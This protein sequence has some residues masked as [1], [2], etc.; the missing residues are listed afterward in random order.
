MKKTF[1]SYNLS[2]LLLLP[3]SIE[4]WVRC[5]C[6][7]I[8]GCSRVR[9]IYVFWRGMAMALNNTALYVG[10]TLGSLIGGWVIAKCA[11][12]TLPLICAVIAL[13]GALTVFIR[14]RGIP[15]RQ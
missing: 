6:H 1:H 2:H 12:A 14:T 7:S 10:I 5:Q 11:F 4:E 15:L 13:L 9:F 8:L 3:P